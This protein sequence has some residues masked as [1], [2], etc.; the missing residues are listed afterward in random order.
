M[1]HVINPITLK[2]GVTKFWNSSAI[3]L[4]LNY[5]YRYNIGNDYFLYKFLRGFFLLIL[6]IMYSFGRKKIRMGSA[7]FNIIN[8][9]FFRKTIRVL[10]GKVKLL[11]LKEFHFLTLYIWDGCVEIF[12]RHY[13]YNII[14]SLNLKLQVK[15]IFLYLFNKYKF[16]VRVLIII[17]NFFKWILFK[18]QYYLNKIYL[19]KF[20]DLFIF[21]FKNI[22]FIFIKFVLNFY[23][24]I[25]CILNLIFG[26]FM[27]ML[28]YYVMLYPGTFLTMKEKEMGGFYFKK[29]LKII[30][31]KKIFVSYFIQSLRAFLRCLFFKKRLRFYKKFAYMLFFFLDSYFIKHI[32]I[33]LS[34][35]HM[36]INSLNSIIMGKYICS[37][38][39]QHFNLMETI[40][41]VVNDAKER[42][43]ILGFHLKCSFAKKTFK[44]F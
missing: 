18:K 11:K 6:L 14:S 25:L 40:M 42:P 3:N 7:N 38:L 41:P 28:N 23:K 16:K 4:H 20:I 1:G 2:S 5:N 8:T 13:I 31:L 21:L 19:K 10:I 27:R 39:L 12:M 32:N 24:N 17:I 34:F 15:N 9:A 43:D 30:I 26:F 22:K 33:N 35:K 37:R 44:Y 29:Y 36:H